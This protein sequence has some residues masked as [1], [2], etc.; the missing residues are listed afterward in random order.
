MSALL[1]W[2]LG[3]PDQARTRGQQ[4]IALAQELPHPFSLAH[5]LCLVAE[6]H[7][8]RRD[9]R[10]TH[11]CAD[12]AIVL[13]TEQGFPLWLAWATVLRGWAQ[14][15]IGCREEGI[16]Q[17]QAG[18]AAYLATGA[19][20]GQSHFLA[21]LAESYGH[22]GQAETGRRTLAE[23]KAMARACG[24]HYCEAELY[25]VEGELACP[26]PHAEVLD[27]HSCAVAQAC[28]DKAISVARH[29]SAKSLELRATLS[30]ARLWQRQ[31]KCGAA[32]ERLTD[33]LGAFT[34]GSDMADLSE[35]N[36]LLDSMK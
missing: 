18:L 21:L 16:A 8:F 29:Q 27:V 14:A 32:K 33:I 25:R 23:A 6:L 36:L 24:E 9:P 35:A 5:T 22:I 30:L 17:M 1:L 12:A 20:L 28:F 19:K 13:S 2:C 31:G 26:D 3:Y 10:L 7:Q 15:E 34:E 4:A 11:D